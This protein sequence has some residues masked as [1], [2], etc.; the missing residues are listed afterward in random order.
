MQA[1]PADLPPLLLQARGRFSPRLA[2][3]RA[4]GLQYRMC[5]ATSGRT[6]YLPP[7]LSSSIHMVPQPM[8]TGADGG[9]GGLWGFFF[10]P[11]KPPN[12]CGALSHSLPEN[13]MQPRPF[14]LPCHVCTGTA[15]VR[16]SALP[17]PRTGLI[18][19]TSA[20]GPR[21]P[22]PHLREDWARRCQICLRSAARRLRA[23]RRRTHLR[24]PHKRPPGARLS[25]APRQVALDSA[26]DSPRRPAHMSPRLW[27]STG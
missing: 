8:R 12:G 6:Q 4:V 13:C 25:P 27:H 2:S 14:G 1:S 20:P 16:G 26:R 11:A 17:H 5:A 18:A 10:S 9:G 22:H 15:R 19:A 24:P 7:T 23:P 21:S 3:P